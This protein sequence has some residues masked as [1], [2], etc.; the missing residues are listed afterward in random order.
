VIPPLHMSLLGDFLL[1]SGETPVTTVTIPRVQSLLA[2]LVLHRGAPQDR[3]HL[4]FLLWPDSVE[5]QAHTNLRQLLYHLRQSLPYANHFVSADRQSLHWHPASDV[6]FTLDVEEFERALAT[7]KHAEQIQDLAGARQALEQATRLYR[8]DL[9]PSCYDEWIFPERDRFHQSFLQAA[10]RLMTLL[11]QERAYSAA[12]TVA[13]QLLRQD[14]LHEAAYRQLMRLHA[15]SGDRAAALRAYHTCASRLEREL[16]TA[17][18][19]ATCQAYET[20]LQ[21]GA[22]PPTNCATRLLKS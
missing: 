7:A 11:E 16:G 22:T 21:Q 13:Q 5:A 18:S 6:T 10:E 3:S 20:L 14:P 4:A 19:E 17:P 8:G 9:F 15:L 1:V 12:I 2:Y